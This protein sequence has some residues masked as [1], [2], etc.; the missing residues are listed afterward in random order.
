MHSDQQINSLKEYIYNLRAWNFPWKCFIDDLLTQ[1]YFVIPARW[2]IISWSVSSDLTDLFFSVVPSYIYTHSPTVV[3]HT[4]PFLVVVVNLDL[5]NVVESS[6]YFIITIKTATTDPPLHLEVDGRNKRGGQIRWTERVLNDYSSPFL[7]G[8]VACAELNCMLISSSS[9]WGNKA[10]YWSPLKCCWDLRRKLTEI[11]SFDV[12]LW[13]PCII[14]AKRLIWHIRIDLAQ[15]LC[16]CLWCWL[17][18][19]TEYLGGGSLKRQELKQSRHG[20]YS[21]AALDSMRKPV[22][23]LSIKCNPKIKLWT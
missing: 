15:L 21:A 8:S 3:D 17:R 7:D 19:V 6:D 4:D 1:I 2:F 9:N 13:T 10:I 23:F 14:Y 22:C 18:S 16:C 20:E 5:Q 11:P 12:T